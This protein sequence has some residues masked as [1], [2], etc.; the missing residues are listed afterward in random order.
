MSIPKIITETNKKRPDGVV[1]ST[2]LQGNR[3]MLLIAFN[4]TFF[5]ETG[6]IRSTPSIDIMPYIDIMA[7]I[8]T[9]VFFFMGIIDLFM[10]RQV[11]RR[12]LNG[13]RYGLI[14]SIINLLLPF[15]ILI[16][17]GV[18]SVLINGIGTL[19]IAIGIFSVA[20]IIALLTQSSRRFYR[21]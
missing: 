20:E 11:W 7:V 19:L 13:W 6:I 16:V 9:S 1:L 3:G 15:Y 12:N 14:M 21:T 17:I 10:T 4:W 18:F 2:L 5:I 8:P